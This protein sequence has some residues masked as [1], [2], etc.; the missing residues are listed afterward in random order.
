MQIKRPRKKDKASV[1]FSHFAASGIQVNNY[2]I[3]INFSISAIT[4]H[5][6]HQLSI[7]LPDL[8]SLFNS[9]TDKIIH[10]NLCKKIAQSIS[11][12]ITC[13]GNSWQ[14]C[15]V[16]Q[17]RKIRKNNEV[18]ILVSLYTLFQNLSYFIWL[19]LGKMAT[20]R[21]EGWQVWKSIHNFHLTLT[22][23]C[24]IHVVIKIWYHELRHFFYILHPYCFS[25]DH[26]QL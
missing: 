21:N 26:D 17:L 22:P 25:T 14:L 1:F 4:S 18:S 20:F 2:E 5:D 11:K 9:W 13:T 23:F 8:P 12:W 16:C 7:N 19:F 15:L 6:I 10:V 24:P 3:V